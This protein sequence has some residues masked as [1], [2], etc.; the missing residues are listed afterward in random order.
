MMESNRELWPAFPAAQ[1]FGVP[2]APTE[3]N[4]VEPPVNPLPVVSMNSPAP[5]P[6]PTPPA[7]AP[8]PPMINTSA[9]EI[10]AGTLQLQGSVFVNV[11]F[12]KPLAVCEVGE[13]VFEL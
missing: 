2:P 4:T 10:P 11:E 5:P 7:P 13:Q 3:I 1:L 6:P 12:V 8:P 9:A